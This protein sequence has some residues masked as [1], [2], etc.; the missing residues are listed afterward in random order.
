MECVLSEVST[1]RFALLSLC[2]ALP[3][4][5]LA[6]AAAKGTHAFDVRD[7]IAFD[8]ISEPKVSPD[9]RQVVFTVSALDFDANKRRSD[10]WLANSDGTGLKKLTRHEAADTSA[11]FAPDGKAIYFLSTRSGSTQVWKLP[12]DVGEPPRVERK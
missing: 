5:P 4:A 11:A 3:F 7:L 12:L 1:M 10:L 9:G 2:L 6:L 8:R